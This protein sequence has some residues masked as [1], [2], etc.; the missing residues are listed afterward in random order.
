M[1][2]RSV[3]FPVARETSCE[4]LLR[5]ENGSLVN[6]LSKKDPA[7]PVGNSGICLV[8]SREFSAEM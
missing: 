1:F 6:V 4:R 5:E 3:I 8:G 7:D 2:L